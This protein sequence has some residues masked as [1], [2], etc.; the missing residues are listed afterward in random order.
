MFG[1][2]LHDLANQGTAII[3]ASIDHD[4]VAWSDELK[5]LVNR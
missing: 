2:R 4:N 3:A 5:R 1:N